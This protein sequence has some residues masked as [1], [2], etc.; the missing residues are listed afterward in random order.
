MWEGAAIVL[1]AAGVFLWL[2]SLR[3]RERAVKAG[4][5]ACERYTL[6]FLDD[7]VSFT[8]IRL[9]R[10]GDGQLRIARTYTFEFSDTGNNR[11]HGA[12]V[13]L[14]GELQDL[15]LEPYRVQ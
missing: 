9:R 13:M 5:A 14:G 12:I 7:T 10:D 8:R 15:Q 6:Q 4:R 1:I 3:A 11:R 2:D